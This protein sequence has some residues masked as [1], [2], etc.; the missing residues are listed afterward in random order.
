[1]LQEALS[2]VT[3]I[4][5]SLKF[6]DFVDD[7]SVLLKGRNKELVEMADFFEEVEEGCGREGSEIVDH[8]EREGRQE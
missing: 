1:M 5:P 3:P 4:Y 7:I 8:G 2:E 6:R